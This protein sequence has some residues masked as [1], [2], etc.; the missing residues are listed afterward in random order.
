[1]G[2]GR[3]KEEGGACSC[4]GK[5][6]AASRKEWRAKGAGGGEEWEVKQRGGRRGKGGGWGMASRG[7]GGRE[8]R[9]EEG[10]KA[11]DRGVGTPFQRLIRMQLPIFFFFKARLYKFTVSFSAEADNVKTH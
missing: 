9:T 1:M 8:Q 11:K 3:W 5:V 4:G 10:R 6:V 7:G 2:E